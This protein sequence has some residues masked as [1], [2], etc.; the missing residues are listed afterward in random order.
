MKYRVT[1]RI[2][3]RVVVRDIDQ[4]V[5]AD[6]EES[7]SELVYEQNVPIVFNGECE[8]D[9][10]ELTITP[11]TEPVESESARLLREGYA[12]LPGFAELLA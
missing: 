8:W 5:E 4:T 7:A 6:D 9:D 2:A 1:G 10:Q 12:P 3:Y 11:I